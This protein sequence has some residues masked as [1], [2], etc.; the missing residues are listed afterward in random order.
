MK[1]S[2]LIPTRNRLELLRQAIATVMGQDYPDWEIIVSDN[3]SEQGV[4]GYLSSLDEPRIKYFR[5]AGFI[6]VTDNWNNAL[7]KSS[8]DYV[9][10]LGDDDC[11]MKGY[12]STV[13]RMI[14]SF[15]EPDFIYTNG[16]LY[17]YP[18]VLPGYPH[19]FL[20]AY[21]YA[22]FFA[23]AREPFWLDKREAVALVRKSMNFKMA[24]TYN[25][26]HSVV[27]RGF[28]KGLLGKGP[29]FQSP[30]PDFYATNVMM[31][32]AERILVCPYHLVTVG[33]SPKS[34]GYYYSN[35]R[36][37][38]GVAFLNNLPDP[39]G[40]GRLQ[41]VILPGL[42][43]KTSWLLAME[44]IR[45][46]YGAETG[47]RV[48][49]NRYRYLQ[50]LH[51]YFKYFRDKRQGLAELAA[52]EALLKELKGRMRWWE[53]LCYPPVLAVTASLAG[54]LP[55]TAR[56]RIISRVMALINKTP[57]LEVRDNRHFGNILEV[58]ENVDPLRGI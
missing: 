11:L 47:L 44:A 30:Y 7:E 51:V 14:D 52:S 53:K 42:Q 26:Q 45:A 38:Q 20:Q 36:E 29:F 28:I 50:I 19:G 23:G 5:T 39:A 34:F 37:E 17:A 24:Y 57:G 2:V 18:G 46:N 43:D 13:A 35:A 32:K 55:K 40:I 3:F 54:L 10:M 6:P 8:G 31:L 22:P 41:E 16:F 58:F 4:A 25:M 21:G 15:G 9:I 27:N 48:G 1:F 56:S 33:V 49:Y 12:F